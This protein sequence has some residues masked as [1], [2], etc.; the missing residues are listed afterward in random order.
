MVCFLPLKTCRLQLQLDSHNL[1]RWNGLI[2]FLFQLHDLMS[3]Y[4]RHC[5]ASISVHIQR[6]FFLSVCIRVFYY[7]VSELFAELGTGLKK[8]SM[9]RSGWA[10]TLYRMA[11]CSQGR[12]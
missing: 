11:T 8:S 2:W 10:W 9:V 12:R 3:Q 7:S 1:H 6:C 5:C 4:V